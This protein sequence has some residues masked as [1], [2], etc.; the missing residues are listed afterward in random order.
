VL[1][2]H[3]LADTFRSSRGILAG[4][5][6]DIV[7]LQVLRATPLVC[8]HIDRDGVDRAFDDLMASGGWLIFYS[9]DV[10]ENPSPYGCTPDLLQHA[11]QVAS[12]R[13]LPIV[14]VAEALDSAG[15][16]MFASSSNAS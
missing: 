16:R 8:Q 1:H 6:R 13:R 5:D 3:F 14:T 10:V 4:V 7:D 9:H 2:K 15:C 12:Q 11:L